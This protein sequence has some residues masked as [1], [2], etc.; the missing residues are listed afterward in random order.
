MR[1]IC[2]PKSSEGIYTS[3]KWMAWLQF[4]QPRKLLMT[5]V[6]LEREKL[7][8]E[9]EDMY[10]KERERQQDTIQKLEERKERMKE[11]NDLRGEHNAIFNDA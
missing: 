7:E 5:L 3:L 9:R 4:P 10:K 1:I 11:M 2:H 8:I 6:A